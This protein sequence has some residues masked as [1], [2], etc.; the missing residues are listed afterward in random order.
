MEREEGKG[1]NRRSGSNRLALGALLGGL[2]VGG[3]APR[4]FAH[5][6]GAPMD[7]QG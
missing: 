3:G 1:L 5:G 7:F 4:E 6:D 2:L